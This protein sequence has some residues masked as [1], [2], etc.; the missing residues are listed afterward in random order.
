MFL[1]I[2]YRKRKVLDPC[3]GHPGNHDE[4]TGRVALGGQEGSRSRSQL[5][6]FLV[7]LFLAWATHGL[8]SSE[9]GF[10]CAV[11]L[12]FRT[13]SLSIAGITGVS[14]PPRLFLILAW[15]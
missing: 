13:V 8:L 10:C 2:A 6:W 4:S 7:R 5:I 3:L 11:P 15:L 1:L 14:H 9:T 12:D